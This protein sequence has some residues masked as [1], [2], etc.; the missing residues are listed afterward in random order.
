[1]CGSEDDAIYNKLATSGPSSK[2]SEM[3]VS[4][5]EDSDVYC[6]QLSEEQAAAL[7]NSDIDSS[8]EGF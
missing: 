5:I 8:F 1:M 2:N 6:N 4:E 7:F 3:P